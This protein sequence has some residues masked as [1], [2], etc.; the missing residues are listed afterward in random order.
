MTHN[1]QRTLALIKPDA[2]AAG[3]AEEIMLLLELHGFTILEKRCLK[4]GWAPMAPLRSLPA[5]FRFQ[6]HASKPYPQPL[7]HTF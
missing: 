2:V 1:M 6:K 7:L 4:V 5:P 3:Q